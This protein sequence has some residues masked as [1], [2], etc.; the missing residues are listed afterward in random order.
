MLDELGLDLAAHPTEPL[1]RAMAHPPDLAV[2]LHADDTCLIDPAG[3]H[4]WPG[5]PAT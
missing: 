1:V 3:T 4:T 5:R 2:T